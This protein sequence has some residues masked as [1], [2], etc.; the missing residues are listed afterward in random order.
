M[1]PYAKPFPLVGNGRGRTFTNTGR[2]LV[3]EN[4]SPDWYQFIQRADTEKHVLLLSSAGGVE[5]SLLVD[6]L[7]EWG[8]PWVFV[9]VVGG[10][11]HTAIRGHADRHTHVSQCRGCGIAVNRPWRGFEVVLTGIGRVRVFVSPSTHALFSF[12][13]SSVSYRNVPLHRPFARRSRTGT[14]TA[15]T[16]GA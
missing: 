11:I 12:P 3:Y 14:R 6:V 13:R 4:T 1:F 15:L 7:R 2:R 5:P 9:F 16:R 8:G 10:R